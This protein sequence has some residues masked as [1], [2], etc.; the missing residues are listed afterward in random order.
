MKR[1]N[2]SSKGRSEEQHEPEWLRTTAAAHRAKLS[3]HQVKRLAEIGV[4]TSRRTDGRLEILA[5][6]LDDIPPYAVRW[7]VR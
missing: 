3:Y 7:P 2:R 1:T 6:S 4:V 5:D